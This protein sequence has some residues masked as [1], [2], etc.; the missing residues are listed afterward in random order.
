MR[1][2]EGEA[3]P[4]FDSSYPARKAKPIKTMA[5]PIKT[6][7]SGV[8]PEMKGDREARFAAYVA[9]YEKSNPVKFAS[10]KENGEFDKIPASFK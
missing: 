6:D 4:A 9:A 7:P 1:V 3:Y 10:K 5:K 8:V 2:G